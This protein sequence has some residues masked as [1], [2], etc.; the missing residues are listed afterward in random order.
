MKRH[1][2]SLGRLVERVPSFVLD[3]PR[4]Y[5]VLPDVIGAVTRHA[6]IREPVL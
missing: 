6:V 3:Y 1:F 2:N 4:D 5:A